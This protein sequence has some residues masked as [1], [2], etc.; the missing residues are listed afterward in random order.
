MRLLDNVKGNYRFA[1]GIAPYSSGV[2][3]M[4]DHEI[5]HAVVLDPVPYRR[6][7]EL[8]ARHLDRLGRPPHA[9][10]AMELRSP[11][12]FTFDGFTAFNEG[13]QGILAAWGLLIDGHN[14]VARTNVAPAPRAPEEPVLSAFSYTVPRAGA[15]TTFIVA[16][17]GEVVE[18]DLTSTSIVREGETSPEAMNEKAAHVL[19]IMERRMATLKVGWSQ[20]GVIDVYTVQPLSAVLAE[21]ILGPMGP[22]CARGL[23]WHYSRPPIE[24][25]E[26]EM[27]LRS[28]RK[29]IALDPPS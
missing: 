2:V 22:H 16:G 18:Q 13:Y 8:V 6:G 7:F 12:P 9:L 27:D 25:L 11:K 21:A 15:P 3:A 23:H 20:V 28:V 19:A 26:F 29:D 17:A 4:A 1:T 5:V 10:C 24:G 14:P